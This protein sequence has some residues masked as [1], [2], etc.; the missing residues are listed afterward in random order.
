MAVRNAYVL[1]EVIK[2]QVNGGQVIAIAGNFETLAADDILSKYRICKV[3]A[4]WTPLRI[5]IN[6]DAIAGATDMNLGLYDT[7]E[8]GGAVKD[9]DCF[10]DG[11]DINAGKALGSEQ[12]GLATL[13]VDEI[14][15]QMYEQAG[16][17]AP[18]PD[19]MYDLVLTADSEITAAG[20]IAF[21]MVFAKAA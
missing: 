7:L 6:C 5:D 2:T 1:S 14:G 18:T 8:N 21:R 4:D 3:G 9:Y 16:D 12:N 11:A 15:D 10:M 20:T 13:P 19:G 17:S